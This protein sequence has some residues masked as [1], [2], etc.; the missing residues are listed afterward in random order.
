MYW[1]TEN[2]DRIKRYYEHSFVCLSEISSQYLLVQKVNNSLVRLVDIEDNVYEVNLANGYNMAF[3]LPA[4]R[5]Y[6]QHKE[7]AYLI[8]RLPARQYKRGFCE[9][10]TEIYKVDSNGKLSKQGLSFTLLNSYGNKSPYMSFKEAFTAFR[11]NTGLVSIALTHRMCVTSRNRV[12]IDNKVIGVIN[13]KTNEI[14]VLVPFAPAI[15]DFVMNNGD[16]FTI[17]PKPEQ[18]KS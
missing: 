10:N 13:Y 6:F 14:K 11:N 3:A 17:I 12:L 4:N 18:V 2:A 8:A 15:R 16:S 5:I 7:N 9:D 1:N